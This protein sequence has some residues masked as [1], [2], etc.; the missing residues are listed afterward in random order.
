MEEDVPVFLG[1]DRF[2]ALGNLKVK[3]KFSIATKLDNNN[4]PRRLSQADPDYVKHP[5]PIDQLA[6]TFKFSPSV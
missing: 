5:K 3:T 1:Q 2:K 6:E 4:E